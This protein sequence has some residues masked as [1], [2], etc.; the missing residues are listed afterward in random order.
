VPQDKVDLSVE[1]G[2][3][4]VSAQRAHQ[5][6]DGQSAINF[7][8]SINRAILLPTGVDESLINANFKENGILE[9]V[10]PKPAEAR[11]QRQRINITAGPIQSAPIDESQQ[12]QGLPQQ[13]LQAG[14]APLQEQVQQPAVP[15]GQQTTT[16]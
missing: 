12:Q 9:V 13:P 11:Q 4:T 8:E 5:A 2:Y 1:N 14:K 3:L 15:A 7:A 6:R 10:V 16:A